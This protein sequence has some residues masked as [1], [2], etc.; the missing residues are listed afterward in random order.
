[1]A[2]LAAGRLML[3]SQAVA[4]LAGAAQVH[5]QL[6]EGGLRAKVLLSARA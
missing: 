2:L 6:E 3:R 1:M 5:R 4:P